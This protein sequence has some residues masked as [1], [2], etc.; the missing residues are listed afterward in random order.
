[1]SGQFAS[2]SPDSQPAQYWSAILYH[3]RSRF[4]RVAALSLGALMLFYVLLGVFFAGRATWY[5]TFSDA[6]LLATNI[7]A[8]LALGY[9]AWSTRRSIRQGSR[10]DGQAV[11]GRSL[12]L[13]WGVMAIAQLFYVLGDA[14]AILLQALTISPEAGLPFPSVADFFYLVYYPLFA[15]GLLILLPAL[16]AGAPLK[17]HERQ[18]I[19]LDIA[20]VMTAAFLLLL[21][22]LIIPIAQD[23][24]ATLIQVLV[25]AAYPIFDL[26]LLF[27]LLRVMYRQAQIGQTQT[28]QRTNPA[29]AL[30]FLQAGLAFTLLT[31]I[32][33]AWIGLEG[34]YASGS[35]IDVLYALSYCLVAMAGLLQAE[36]IA[37]RP[38]AA[39]PGAALAARYNW[40]T[41]APYL[42]GLLTFLLL[43]FYDRLSVLPLALL[44]SVVGLIFILVM[45]RQV[46][47][48]Q[49]NAE[50]Y[51]EE[52][53]RRQLA[54]ALSRAAGEIA[55]TLDHQ[56][57]P[58]LILDQLALVVPYE[59]CSI[60]LQK[61]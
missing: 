57:T 44:T 61:D 9:A 4:F 55:S 39:P 30:V 2:T 33:Y 29:P 54:E 22:F 12:H 24:E 25:S 3:Q 42:A 60:L 14:A 27:M 31:D 17:R 21:N 19:A 53:R 58:G 36:R 16:T 11:H 32:A 34:S 23:A 59:R 15:A 6:I 1:M 48:M 5:P 41:Y 13:A 28:G 37:P 8:T 49:E 45:L 43:A 26:L 18:K 50:L 47:S 10:F 38:F 46:I 7:S 56:Q 52:Q 40:M 35:L 20:I 51:R